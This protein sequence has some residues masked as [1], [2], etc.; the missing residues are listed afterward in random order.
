MHDFH[1]CYL[2]AIR[3][4]TRYISEPP[5][6]RE[7]RPSGRP[8]LT[9]FRVIEIDTG[10]VIADLS[11]GCP[12]G[13]VSIAALVVVL[14]SKLVFADLTDFP[15]RDGPPVDTEIWSFTDNPGAAADFEAVSTHTVLFRWVS[16]GTISAAHM[17]M[18]RPTSVGYK[19]KQK[20]KAKWIF[21]VFGYPEKYSII[22]SC[23]AHNC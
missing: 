23:D 1:S 9:W 20:E 11:L 21:V 6:R 7:E 5:T 4:L 13:D 19:R 14:M 10:D 17:N 3:R 2:P 12:A 16:A 8:D 15:L 22:L 18:L